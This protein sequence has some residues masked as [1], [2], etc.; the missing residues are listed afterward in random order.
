MDTYQWLL[1]QFKHLGIHHYF[2]IN[3]GGALN[4]S[5]W[6]PPHTP[7]STAMHFISIH[8]YTAGF[9]PI[10]H[11]LANKQ[12]AATLVTTGAA[13]KLAAAGASDACF[14]GVPALFIFALSPAN[15]AKH[16][17]VQDTSAAGT[18]TKAQLL[19]EFPKHCIVMDDMSRIDKNL[20][21]MQQQ[22]FHNQPVVLLFHPD[23]IEKTLPPYLLPF[24]F[25]ELNSAI[26]KKTIHQLIQTLNQRKPSQK[27]VILCASESSIEQVNPVLLQ[28]FISKTGA[29]VIYTT[30]GDNIA[31]LTINNN[32]GHIMFGGNQPAIDCWQHLN[33]QDILITLGL[34]CGEYAFNLEKCHAGKVF[35]FTHLKNGYAQEHQSYQ[36][37]FTG[38]YQQINGSIETNLQT[39]LAQLENIDLP[40]YTTPNQNNTFYLT[41]SPQNQPFI[42]PIYFYQQLEQ[43]WQPNT[44]A[45]EDICMAYRD[46]PA[47]LK[48]PSPHCRFF[49]AN[50]G[51]ALG[52]AFGM[53]AG[54]TV[55]QPESKVFIFM[56]DGGFR[57]MISSLAETAHLNLTVF[58]FDNACF[59]IVDLYPLEKTSTE[60]VY[61][62][63]EL[64]NIHWKKVG[65]GMGWAVDHLKPDCENLTEL[66]QKA[67]SEDQQSTMIIV[68]ADP[69]LAIGK[70]FRYEQLLKQ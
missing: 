42:D 10:G 34:D 58:I 53:G 40:T 61:K 37:L 22:L 30:N 33:H 28:K 67:Y 32:L 29:E 59:G 55:A 38:D 31:T 39:L 2:G 25:P 69:H 12:P 14:L 20:L 68:P 56:G 47:I 11:Y 6:L 18:N 9:A 35:C 60:R 57:Y 43:L 49:S 41:R 51:S 3:G 7:H 44:L 16:Y 46:R 52:S 19:A 15:Q 54:A 62:H 70:N 13:S 36:H 50:Q 5:K 24:K 21:Q 63:S 66:L 45:F 8:E 27:L 1:K 23:L 65:E 48:D 4:L 17:P 64:S 26:D